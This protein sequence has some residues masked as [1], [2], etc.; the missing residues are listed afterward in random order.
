MF[1]VS[2]EIA[3]RL[4][5][6]DTRLPTAGHGEHTAEEEAAIDAELA[7]LQERVHAVG[8]HRCFGC[9]RGSLTAALLLWFAGQCHTGRPAAR[10][11]CAVAAG[12]PEH[13]AVRVA[14]VSV[15]QR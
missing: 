8:M 11:E 1:R 7:Q 3:E 2:P 9:A 5:Q 13:Q 14:L 12:C 4:R 15:E 10:G 6:P